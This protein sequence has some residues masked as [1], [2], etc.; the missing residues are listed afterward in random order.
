[1][2]KHLKMW[3]PLF[4]L[5]FGIMACDKEETADDDTLVAEIVTANSLVATTPENLPA[6]SQKYITDNYFDTYVESVEVAADKGYRVVLGSGENLFFTIRGR[7]IEFEG[8]VRPNGPFG[9]NPPHGP[10]RRLARWLRGHGGN[11]DADGDGVPDGPFA[12]DI[13]ELPTAITDYVAAEYPDQ[14]IRRAAF[15]DDR[16]LL[17][18]NRNL[19]L[20]F[21]GDGNFLAEVNPLEHCIRRC[22]GLTRDELPTEVAAYLVANFPDSTFRAACGTERGTLVL[23]INND[24]RLVLGFNL[25]GELVFQRP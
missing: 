19:V 5:V 17:L 12:F 9:N 18:L 14:T 16:F 23:L 8:E 2:I 10:C 7:D 21:D 1:M 22:N 20:A 25:A 24:R 4:L 13:A 3:L 15:R 11:H 6:T